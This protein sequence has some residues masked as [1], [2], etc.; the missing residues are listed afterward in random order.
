MDYM[1]YHCGMRLVAGE[2]EP[3]IV[4]QQLDRLKCVC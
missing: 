3:D 4:S 1:I 2:P